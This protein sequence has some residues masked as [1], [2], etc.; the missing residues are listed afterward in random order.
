MNYMIINDSINNMFGVNDYAHNVSKTHYCPLGTIS[1]IDAQQILEMMDRCKEILLS[2]S[3]SNSPNPLIFGGDFSKSILGDP[4]ISSTI[5]TFIQNHP[6]IQVLS[7]DD[8]PEESYTQYTTPS[9]DIL[10]L[11]GNG[12]NNLNSLI[13][14][15][16]TENSNYSI[17]YEAL[18][19]CTQ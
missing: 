8:I 19:I 11:Y 7:I 4:A 5:F 6:W 3:L 9:F 16:K 12:T 10:N 2:N 17:I 18:S 13:T 14:K 1:S 15:D